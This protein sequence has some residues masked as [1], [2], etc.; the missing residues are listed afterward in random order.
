MSP[1]EPLRDGS[2]ASIRLTCTGMSAEAAAAAAIR[3]A[4]VSIRRRVNGAEGNK[5]GFG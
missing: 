3:A 5:G 2:C 1:S 4:V